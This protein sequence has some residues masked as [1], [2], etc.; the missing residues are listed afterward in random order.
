MY[1]RDPTSTHIHAPVQ[2]TPFRDTML[3]GDPVLQPNK[4]DSTPA[5]NEGKFTHS[6]SSS[7]LSPRDNPSENTMTNPTRKPSP[8]MQSPHEST[9]HTPHTIPTHVR[10]SRLNKPHDPL[11]PTQTTATTTSPLYEPP[12]LQVPSLL[13]HRNIAPMKQQTDAT[14][15]PQ[16]VS[17]EPTHAVYLTCLNDN[18]H[19]NNKNNDNHTKHNNLFLNLYYDELFNPIPQRDII[20]AFSWIQTI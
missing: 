10:T 3:G 18:N 13:P 5:T 17:A 4:S 16:L 12:S 14:N 7:T 11:H 20:S 9:T 1:M 19:N 2:G 6:T 15:I 8:A